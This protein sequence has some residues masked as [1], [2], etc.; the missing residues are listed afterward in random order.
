MSMLIQGPKQPGT[1]INLYLGL[2]K[3]ELAKLWES[4]ANTYDAVAQD[5]FTMRVA[6]VT[7]VQYYLDCG[8]I[9]GQVIQ[10]FS[11]CVRC[12]D[13][14]SYLQLVKDLGSSKTV[15]MAH[16]RWL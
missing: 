2:L 9:S 14:T 3:E 10:G 16:R 13:K 4:R 8:Y 11:A 6:L 7:M 12:M 1:D 15:F 5:Y